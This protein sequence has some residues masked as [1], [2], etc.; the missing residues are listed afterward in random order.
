M[1]RKGFYYNCVF[2]LCVMV[3]F[4]TSV[5]VVAQGESSNWLFGRKAGIN[6]NEGA[7]TP[8]EN[9]AID[10]NEGCASISNSAGELLFYTDGILVWDKNHNVMP[11]GSNLFGNKSSTQS[12]VVVPK[13]N[14]DSIYYIFTV[15]QHILG[16]V[17]N[18][19]FLKLRKTELIL[20]Q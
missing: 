9:G 5:N 20:R 12:A 2:A 19:V 1:F 4:F 10:T 3:S 18:L 11:N 16:I 6:F 7:V 17:M 15:L 8:I 14:S 13:P